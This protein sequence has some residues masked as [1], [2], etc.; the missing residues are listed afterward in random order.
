MWV[1]K[2]IV[3]PQRSRASRRTV[4]ILEIFAESTFAVG[5]SRS[6]ALGRITSARTRATRCASPALNPCAGRSKRCSRSRSRIKPVIREAQSLLATRRARRRTHTHGQKNSRPP[7]LSETGR[8]RSR[9]SFP[10][11]GGPAV[12]GRTRRPP[13]RRSAGQRKARRSNQ[14]QGT[15][16]AAGCQCRPQRPLRRRR[17]EPRSVA[18]SP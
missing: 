3:V 1:E 5:S 2:T 8:L 4:S 17:G 6:S 13:P 9:T 11:T 10:S 14:I 12:T 18:S 7:V 16:T 15:E